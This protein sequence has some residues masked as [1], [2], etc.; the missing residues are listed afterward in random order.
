[1]FHRGASGI[2][3]YQLRSKRIQHYQCASGRFHSAFSYSSLLL[4]TG[5]L[6][7]E[8]VK[9]VGDSTDHEQ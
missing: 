9:I 6:P 3:W 8:Q 4:L 5:A 2:K 7:D 1:M